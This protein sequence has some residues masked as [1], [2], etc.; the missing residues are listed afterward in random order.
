MI[1]IRNLVLLRGA[2]GAGK[3]FFI[4]KNKLEQFV[5]SAD[6]IRLLF[7]TPVM[8]ESG[9]FSINSRNDGKVWK[10]L[11][12]LL[13]ERMKR[14]EFTIID[15]THAKQEMISQYKDLAQKYR[16]RV[17]VVDFSDIPLETLLLQNRMRDEHKH[18]PEHVI[19]NVHERMQTEHVPKWVNVIKPEEFHDTVQFEQ[20]IYENY[21]YI[22]HFGDIHGSYEALMEYFAKT[23]HA[24]C[25]DTGYPILKENEL[26]IFVG[27]ITDRGTQNAEVLNF[28]LS[29]YALKNVVILEG[30]H[31]IHLW[32][33]ANDEDVRSKEF[34]DF[35]QPQLEKPFKYLIPV[36]VEFI[37]ELEEKL[38]EDKLK[39]YK[40]E[41]RQFYRRLRQVVCYKAHGKEVVVT[42]GGLSKMP[43]NLMYLATEQLIKGVGDY[44]VDID[45]AWDNNLPYI[46]GECIYATGGDGLKIPYA[47]EV[48]KKVE[49][50]QIHGHRNIFRLPVQAGKYSFNLEGQVEFGGHLRVVALDA[51]GF[52]ATEVKNNNFKIRKGV[53]PKHIDETDTSID[54]LIAYMSNHEMI[55]EKDLGGNIYSY[56]FTRKAF[57]DKVWDDINVKARGLFINKNTKE[58]VS[59]SYN[60]FFNVNERSFTKINALADN[61]VFPVQVYDKPNGY[62][63]IVGYDSESDELVFSSKSSTGGEFAGWF[64]ELFIGQFGSVLEA[65]KQELKDENIA[66]VFEVI[67]VKED[68]H[69]IEYAEDKLV[70]LDLVKRTVKY[71]K[72]PYD[73]VVQ[74]ARFYGLEHKNLM[75]TFDNWTD[76]YIWYRDVTNDFSID[77]N[78][79]FVIEDSAGFMT[80]IKLP[81]YSFW[82]QFRNIK[83]LFAKRHEHTVKGGSLYTPLHNRVF[84]WMKGQDRQWLK[85]TDIITIRKA[86]LQEQSKE[87]L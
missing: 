73:D 46:Y 40:K 2:M 39:E 84:K 49:L 33:W 31:E 61:M 28:F 70:L 56:N 76:F 43:D 30:N 58:I 20:T 45:N 13:E 51:E 66:L 67:K 21:D 78:E 22:H 29:I 82:K 86:Y 27:D 87:L 77:Y 24:F 48:S 79:G 60:K 53:V 26:Y 52:H 6:A 57:K 10:L 50:Y 63:G 8:T 81:F 59:R 72:L 12:E 14:G 36:D 44:E 18:V 47:L 23:G 37:D 65:I 5:L 74:F 75:H 4:K 80:K 35:T 42:H 69:I 71:E 15:A 62:L 68:P 38:D 3:S 64:K 19:M 54:Q 17:H 32:N 85:R 34:I 9:K 83:D 16:Y 41:V 55:E 7:Q 25:Q 1:I 11:F